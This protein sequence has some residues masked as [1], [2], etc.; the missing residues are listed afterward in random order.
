M[1][2]NCT[3]QAGV[4]S[5]KDFKEKISP[6][7]IIHLLMTGLF[8][9]D[10]IEGEQAF[11]YLRAAR[12]DENPIKPY[13]YDGVCVNYNNGSCVLKN[14]PLQCRI[15]IEVTEQN[16]EHK[17]IVIRGW[18]IYQTDLLFAKQYYPKLKEITHHLY[19]KDEGIYTNYLIKIRFI[20]RKL[21]KMHVNA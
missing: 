3:T 13:W 8:V 1:E 6:E 20:K 21:L 7:F 17:H 10:F 9:I 4:Y 5:P 2:K 12:T 11:L 18:A 19:S 16:T 15:G 14:K